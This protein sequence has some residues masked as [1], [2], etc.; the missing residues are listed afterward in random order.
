MLETMDAMFLDCR[1][2]TR[3]S[4]IAFIMKLGEV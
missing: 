4:F 1:A 3:V 2:Y